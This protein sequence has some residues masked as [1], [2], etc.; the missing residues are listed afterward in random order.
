[1]YVD[2]WGSHSNTPDSVLLMPQFVF[3]FRIKRHKL[4]Q[5]PPSTHI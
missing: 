5:F 4:L 1:M 2:M 3:F